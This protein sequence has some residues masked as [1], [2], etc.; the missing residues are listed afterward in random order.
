M[1]NEA[2]GAGGQGR[3]SM[4]SG[5]DGVGGHCD[6]DH[7]KNSRVCACGWGGGRRRETP[8]LSLPRPRP[9]RR[10]RS[11]QR[12]LLLAVAWTTPS[13]PGHPAW[14]ASTCPRGRGGSSIVKRRHTWSPAHSSSAGGAHMGASSSRPESAPCV[15]PSESLTGRRRGAAHPTLQRP[16]LPPRV[17]PPTRG[18]PR[19][20]T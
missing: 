11:D 5:R 13:L 10:T 17:T 3:A 8:P 4:R 2:G 19:S 16:Q 12:P 7:L 20:T 9:L 1:G 14:P 6:V 18:A 15:E